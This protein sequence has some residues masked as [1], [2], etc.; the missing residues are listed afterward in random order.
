MVYA[1]L[2]H[3][4]IVLALSL[5]LGHLFL[6]SIGIARDRAELMRMS[7]RLSLAAALA[8]LISFFLLIAAFLH[9]DFSLSYVAAQSSSL[10]PWF[11][12]VSASWGGHAGSLLMWCAILYGWIA[13]LIV[14][15][16]HL[17]QALKS[18]I[19][20]TLNVVA[21]MILLLLII[22]SNPFERTLP[23]IPVDGRDLNPLLQ[24]PGLIFHPP[25]LY[26][27]YVGTSVPF[28]FA[29]AALWLGRV[30]SAWARWMRPWTLV[31]WSCLTFGIAL[32]AW[33][34]YTELGWGGWWFWD[35][36]ENASLMPWL[37]VTALM[38]SLYA[39]ESRGVF[40]A[41]TLLLAIAAFSLSLLG[42]FLV[43]SGVLTSV[44]AFASDP[45]LG[46]FILVILGLVVG[47]SL[48]L[49]TVRAPKL[50]T[51]TRFEL[52]S[53]ES[54]LAYNNLLITG[55]LLVVLLGTLYPIIAD[56]FD[57]G[58]VSVGAPYFNA[59]FVPLS[60]LLIVG[61][62]A[63]P[64]VR[65]K[66]E[67]RK[68]NKPLAAM[69]GISVILGVLT[70]LLYPEFNWHVL[71]TWVLVYW[72]LCFSVLDLYLRLRFAPS[73]LAGIRRLP[74][75]FYSMSL[76]HLGV[77]VLA[78]GVMQASQMSVDRDAALRV[79]D[80][81]EIGPYE[82]RMEKLGE[83]QAQNFDA[84]VAQISVYKEG[85]LLADLMPE[86]RR[87]VV[88]NQS[89]TEAATYATLGSDLYVSLGEPLTQDGE[90]LGW[91]V[92][93]S[94]KSGVH[95]LWLGSLLMGFGGLL[96]AWDKRSFQKAKQVTP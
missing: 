90:F 67:T 84:Y 69:I 56:G 17:P 64:V 1:E 43:R 42:T 96:G 31:A 13:A 65:W 63:A 14:W 34:A 92:R 32:G 93:V 72:A 35:P 70:S 75:K 86:K 76:G 61:M 28:A 44:H 94:I 39:T 60:W 25:I 2:G 52:I 3:F 18:R 73:K 19:I 53:K 6:G 77:L 83:R 30:D 68:I 78:L 55:A 50:K 37:A 62:T 79:G 11:Y 54:M 45:K 21:I 26:M 7:E 80:T 10:T 20:W 8:I 22:T 38:H 9:N 51:L 74:I 95:W 58:V 87:Y 24:D 5:C 12:K 85:S 48:L 4:L 27:G 29:I 88:D 16:G 41:W 15:G 36:V 91:S 46:F 66:K 33:W 40:K 23:L 47:C 57:L 49:Y 82:L 59:L 71:I 81:L 89:M